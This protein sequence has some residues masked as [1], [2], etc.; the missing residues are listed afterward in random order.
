MALFIREVEVHS[1]NIYTKLLLCSHS[2]KV[3]KDYLMFSEEYEIFCM[4]NIMLY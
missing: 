3:V 4:S 2:L 1:R